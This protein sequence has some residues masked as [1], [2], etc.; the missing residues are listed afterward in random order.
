MSC[1]STYLAFRQQVGD[2]L[3]I[4]VQVEAAAELEASAE[5]CHGHR[6]G[7]QL[8]HASHPAELLL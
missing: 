5:V 2:E 1:E 8:L 3:R 7:R 6:L 4:V